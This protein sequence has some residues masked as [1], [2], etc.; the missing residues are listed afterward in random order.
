V[1]NGPWD[2]IFSG[3]LEGFQVEMHSNPESLL[4]ITVI[5]KENEEIKGAVIEIYKVFHAEGSIEDFIETL[6][7]EATVLFKH[8]PKETIKFLLLS[9]SPSYV[10]YEEDPF[11]N[12]AD[13][14]MKKVNTS[15]S[16]IKDFSKA[17]DLQLTELNKAPE[18]IK[19]SFF[20][21]PL[22]APILFP[23]EIEGKTPTRK[24]MTG[25]G[26]IMLGL[27]KA[28][29]M[30]NE[31]IELMMKTTIF[32]STPKDRKHVIHL[33]AEGALMSSIPVIIFDWD[34]S[35]IGLNKPNP[36]AKVLKE[37]NVD[38]EP[39]GFPVKHFTRDDVSVDLNLVSVKGLLELIGMK[40]GEEQRM[41]AK[42]IKETRPESM[43]ELI[44][45]AKKMFLRDESKVANKYRTIRILSLL[46]VK[47]KGLFK[48]KND[49]KEISKNWARSIGRAGII[50]M[51]GLDETASMLLIHN[52][53]KSIYLEYSKSEEE[54]GTMVLLPEIK[55]VLSSKNKTI[56]ATEIIELL[57]KLK[58][59]G[60][61]F[62]LSSD[63]PIDLRKEIVKISEA[64]I[65]LINRNDVGVKVAKSKQFRI[66]L[67]PSLSVSAA[68]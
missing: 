32:G 59:V 42:L 9:S 33:I 57:D 44:A 6:P 54:I 60:A 13:E 5:E 12:E 49:I 62:A 63:R 4:L 3:N 38:L 46:E 47:Y 16:M 36:E 14:L 68:K 19:S 37:Y 66:K 8:E 65:F 48:G 2:E 1:G 18:R 22:I 53:L 21:Q 24:K 41:I 50:H 29:T 31:P 45:S 25:K 55:N 58:S 26:V 27:T 61:G 52:I 17:Y 34:K 43:Q 10:K 35:F 67:R 20:S 15:S 39:I 51:E 23:K 11:C 7:K 30:I 28:N 64:E 56:I 40:E